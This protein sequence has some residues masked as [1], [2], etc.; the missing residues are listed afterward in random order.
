MV[1]NNKGTTALFYNHHKYSKSGES[2]KSLQYR[3][4]NYMKHCR[5][6]I[7]VYRDTQEVLKNEISHNHDYDPRMYER[8]MNAATEIR[9]YGESKTFKL[10]GSDSNS[11]E[12]ES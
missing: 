3:C 1:T 9:R 12:G 10:H 5:S 11:S 8:C 4:V 6:R 7:I 2:K